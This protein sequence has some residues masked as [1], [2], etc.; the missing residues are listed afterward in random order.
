MPTIY[1]TTYELP[2]ELTDNWQGA[3]EIEAEANLYWLLKRLPKRQREVVELTL[4]GFSEREVAD[5]LDISRRSVRT[6]KKRCR[7]ILVG[8]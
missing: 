4:E 6:Y 1:D 3:E 7:P 8:I 2:D 5:K